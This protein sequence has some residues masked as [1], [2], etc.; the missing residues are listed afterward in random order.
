MSILLRL[1]SDGWLTRGGMICATEVSR[2]VHWF[3]A[4]ENPCVMLNFYILGYQDWTFDPP[5]GKADGMLACVVVPSTRFPK[6]STT[7]SSPSTSAS[8]TGSIC[9]VAVRAPGANVIVDTSDSRVTK[10]SPDPSSN[11]PSSAPPASTSGAAPRVSHTAATAGTWV[12]S[13]M[14]VRTGNP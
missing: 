7:V 6:P 3:A 5:D 14:S 10:L 1:R 2:N 11:C 13:W 9:S 8:A 4:D 12:A